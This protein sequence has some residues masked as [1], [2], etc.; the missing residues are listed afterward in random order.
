M[1]NFEYS[2]HFITKYRRSRRFKDLYKYYTLLFNKRTY[3][4]EELS[5][6]IIG[7]H[8]AE[9]D[10]KTY[11]ASLG[12]KTEISFNEFKSKA[13]NLLFCNMEEDMRK[14][15]HRT[16]FWGLLDYD[17]D[18]LKEYIETNK[19]IIF[20]GYE[21]EWIDVRA[22]LEDYCNVSSRGAMIT[23]FGEFIGR[24]FGISGRSVLKLPLKGLHTLRGCFI[25]EL[26]DEFKY[27]E[28]R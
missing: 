14:E 8:L 23:M 28:E 1:L 2:I 18:L 7:L 15:A 20:D 6:M 5:R 11:S 27:M 19:E 17:R 12:L 13:E 25:E 21:I 4:N 3:S 26:S 24:S 22:W 10:Y 9:K 16:K